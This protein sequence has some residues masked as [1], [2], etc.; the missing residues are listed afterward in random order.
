M[1]IQPLSPAPAPTM[2]PAVAFLGVVITLVVF[3]AAVAA[4]HALIGA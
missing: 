1:N 3:F 4:F 2:R